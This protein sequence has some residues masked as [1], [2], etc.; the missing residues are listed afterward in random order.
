M[1]F[2]KP[3]GE[4]HGLVAVGCQHLDEPVEGKDASFF[5]AVHASLYFEMDAAVI[6]DLDIMVG[7]VPDF[8]G[9]APRLHSHYEL[10]VLHGGAQIIFTNIKNKM[11]PGAF[12]GI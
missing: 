12:L 10:K 8:L 5:E 1:V 4:W 11:M 9:G 2:P 7:I 6:D 3:G